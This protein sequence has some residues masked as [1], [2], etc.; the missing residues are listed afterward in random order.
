VNGNGDTVRR[1]APEPLLGALI[2]AA[3]VAGIVLVAAFPSDREVGGIRG[4]QIAFPLQPR[5]SVPVAPFGCPSVLS[6]NTTFHLLLQTG[7]SWCAGLRLPLDSVVQFEWGA[8]GVNVTVV[9]LFGVCVANCFVPL[10]WNHEVYNRSGRSGNGS[11]R[12]P[13]EWEGTAYQI[14]VWSSGCGGEFSTS[15]CRG[16]SAGNVKVY[17]SGS[18]S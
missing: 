1:R 10:E 12:I 9:G 14:A 6:T 18:I 8:V 3:V 4:A 15:D 17:I 11:Y 13:P 16:P 7:F 5:A 2:S